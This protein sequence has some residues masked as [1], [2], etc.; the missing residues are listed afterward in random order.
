MKKKTSKYL[1]QNRNTKSVKNCC[2]KKME[3][4]LCKKIDLPKTNNGNE[5]AS[6]LQHIQRKLKMDKK[7]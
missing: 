7:L 3:P 6:F 4:N 1:K 2:L 5:N